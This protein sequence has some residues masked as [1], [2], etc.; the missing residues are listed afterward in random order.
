MSALQPTVKPL[1]AGSPAT[2][3]IADQV[4]GEKSQA[5]LLK[6][7]G[8]GKKRRYKGGATPITIMPAA[9]KETG[10]TGQT[11]GDNQTALA[12]AQNQGGANAVY[13]NKLGGSR[14]RR[15]R[16]LRSCNYKHKHSTHH[17]GTKTLRHRHS[18]HHKRCSSRRKKRRMS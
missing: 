12:I 2:S 5:N 10:G 4:A 9:Y 16:R 15:L 13:D 6:A 18:T 17:H 3:A 1:S 14:R 7:V 11:V 8:G